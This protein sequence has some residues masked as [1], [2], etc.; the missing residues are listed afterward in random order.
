MPL[1]AVHRLVCAAPMAL[2][3]FAA[4]ATLV[5]LATLASAQ[6]YSIYPTR[7]VRFVLPTSPAGSVD[8]Y[9]RLIA[10]EMQANLGQSFIIE[11]RPGATGLIGI[12]LVRRAAADGYA[13]LFAS[14]TTLVLGPLPRVPRPFDAAQDFTPISKLFRYPLYLLV[15]PSLPARSIKEFIAFARARPGQLV[16]A[17]AGTAA[18]SHVVGE[19]FG[20][21]TGVKVIHAPY[22]GPTPALLSTVA[23]E[24][25]FVF[26]NIG[27]SQPLVTAGKLC[28]LAITGATRSPALPDMPT[29]TELG[30]RGFDNVYTWVGVVAPAHLPQPILAK[31]SAEMTR[32][33]RTPEM[34]KRILNDGYVPVVNT[35]AQFKSDIQAEVET[36]SRVIRE[37]GIKAE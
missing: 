34:E 33:M 22:K 16:Y 3:A 2:A 1:T 25:H 4:L 31:L 18:M 5:A 36:W 27:A 24:T 10:R 11:N 29:M 21:A 26:N 20:D 6:D 28:G 23:G 7:L 14:N 32:I 35:P 17:S 15:H 37:R 13:V 30:M 12:E 8:N 19:L 9:A